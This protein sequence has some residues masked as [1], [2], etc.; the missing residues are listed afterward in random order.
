MFSPVL[1][2]KI[3]YADHKTC[4]ICNTII[5]TSRRAL[6]R[7]VPL[8]MCRHHPQP[9]RSV[10]FSVGVQLIYQRTLPLCIVSICKILVAI[11]SSCVVCL[12]S[13]DKSY[14]CI[15]SCMDVILFHQFLF[16]FS[17]CQ[18]KTSQ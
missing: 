13:C 3:F 5:Y 7:G 15:I 12:R 9:S 17:F 2:A 8:T 18:T 16:I 10:H 6:T 14:F 11:T 4:K 1:T